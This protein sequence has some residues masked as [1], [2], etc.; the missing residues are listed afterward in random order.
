MIKKI[1]SLLLSLSVA[2]TMVSNIT[3]VSAAESGPKVF[4]KYYSDEDMQNEITSNT[5]SHIA[6]P[7]S[8]RTT[9][10]LSQ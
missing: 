5:V 1:L 7:A 10:L 3:V 8:F 4:V 6:P 2:M 9:G